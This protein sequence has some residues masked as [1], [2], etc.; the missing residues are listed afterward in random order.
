M[1]I[2]KM[3]RYKLIKE[4]HEFNS[5]IKRIYELM[6]LKIGES[7]ITEAI[8]NPLSK[9]RPALEIMLE[10]FG[11]TKGEIATEARINGMVS[12][13]ETQVLN[14]GEES[15]IR[16]LSEIGEKIGIA[17]TRAEGKAA[18]TVFLREPSNFNLVLSN[19]KLANGRLYEFKAKEY[20]E[21]KL[22]SYG[23]QTLDDAIK[24]RNKKGADE[25]YNF[26]KRYNMVG[27][28]DMYFKDYNPIVEAIVDSSSSIKG[29]FSSITPDTLETFRRVYSR[30]F[31]SQKTLSEE[32]KKIA[33]QAQQKMEGVSSDAASETIDYELKKMRDI[34]QSMKKFS[35]TSPEIIYNGTIREGG[36]LQGLKDFIPESIQKAIANDTNGVQKF[37]TELKANRKVWTPLMEDAKGLMEVNPFKIPWFSDTAGYAI[38]KDPKKLLPKERL[39]NFVLFLDART[40]DEIYKGLVQRGTGGAVAANTIGR[41][42]ITSYVVPV[43]TGSL[44]SV[45]KT[46]LSFIEFA[47]NFVLGFADKEVDFVDWNKKGTLEGA[48]EQWWKEVSDLFPQNIAG[49][50]DWRRQTYL[51]EVGTV[52]KEFIIGASHLSSK[53]WI[54]N[55]EQRVEQYTL[56]ERQKLLSDHPELVQMGFTLEVLSNPAKFGEAMLKM[57]KDNHGHINADITDDE[58]NNYIRTDLGGETPSEI[59]RMSDK[60]VEIYVDGVT[61]PI[62]VIYKNTVDGKITIK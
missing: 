17:T 46:S 49:L 36:K 8:A 58:I 60:S 33:E 21:K 22:K 52:L 34:L 29:F 2:S 48:F 18:L 26:C 53:E 4:I 44:V 1:K 47:T 62:A 13:F 3:E 5:E 20:V 31:T 30:M 55:I 57:Q 38:F 16:T 12:K 24:L 19:F 15:L 43:I 39:M 6:D 51:D 11:F 40:W 14:S 61:G 54:R 28:M 27:K 50:L 10:K 35:G 56:A 32:F 37:F 42:I 41:L 23:Q 7:Q 9:I 59:K 25:F 45:W